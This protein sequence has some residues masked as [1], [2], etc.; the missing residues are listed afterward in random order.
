[1]SQISDTLT[2]LHQRF[3]PV[4]DTPLLDAQVLVA[5]VLGQSRSWLLAHPE[6]VLSIAQLK[7]I[8]QYTDRIVSGEPLPYILGKWEFYGL[9]FKITPDTLIPR[10]ETEILVEHALAFCKS[11]TGDILIIDAGTGSGCIAVSLAV[12][13]PGTAG[14][15]LAGDISLPALLI[16]GENARK[17]HVEKRINF[18]VCDLLPPLVG[19]VDILCAN[20][21]Y[22][23]SDRLPAAKYS[24]HEPVLALN[25]GPD[26]LAL[27]SRI[28]KDSTGRIS[29][30][31]L[32]LLEI[33]PDSGRSVLAL[34]RECYPDAQ[35][36]LVPDLAGHDR[37]LRIQ[38]Q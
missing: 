27:V 38:L 2:D 1:M 9:E 16:A 32:I 23:P 36:K 6:F 13:L 35:I 7:I 18:L 22:I 26:G 15:I 37:M 30:G 11:K 5:F 3:K 17:H 34:A 33:D 4:S 24:L 28:L 14:A 10:P 20:L 31:G 19:T 8:Y 29:G 12:H 25:G 21:P